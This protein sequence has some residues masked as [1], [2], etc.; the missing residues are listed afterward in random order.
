MEKEKLEYLIS[1]IKE[2]AYEQATREFSGT[3]WYNEFSEK[4]DKLMEGVSNG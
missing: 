1:L 3:G 4:L 2:L